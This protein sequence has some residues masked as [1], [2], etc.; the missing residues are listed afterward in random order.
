MPKKNTPA[1]FSLERGRGKRRLIYRQVADR[2]RKE[3]GDGRLKPGEMLPSMDDLARQ[4]NINKATVRQAIAEL[5]AAGCVHSIPAKGTFVSEARTAREDSSSRLSIGWV[6][7]I[8]DEGN[9]GR[10]H[11]EI[12]DAVCTALRKKRGHLLMMSANGL[13]AASFCREIGEARL[14]GV[15]LVGAYRHDTIRRLAGSGLPMVLLDDACRG[16]RID[17]ILVDNRG[18]GYLAAQ[19]LAALGHRRLAFVTGPSNL[20]ITRDRLDGALEALKDAGL[21]PASARIV[22]SDFSPRGGAEAFQTIAA[23]KP[24]P[25]GVFFFND[26]MASGA[27][28]ALYENTSLKVPEDFSFVGFDD[29]SWASLTHP[30]LTTIRVEKELMGRQAVERLLKRIKDPDHNPTTTIIPTQLVTRNSTAPAHTK[31]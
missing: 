12:M 10:Y 4:F 13:S 8:S 17:S 29:I 23:M 7:S 11:T 24:L 5:A 6:I 20:Q 14:D 2:L 1:S 16:A 31:R 25:T 28:Q 19:H 18:G 3:I 22:A 27:L 15:I 21:D 9:T 30:R 26:E